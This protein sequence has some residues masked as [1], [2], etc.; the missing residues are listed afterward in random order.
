MALNSRQKHALEEFIASGVFE[1]V[2]KSIDVDTYDRFCSTNDIDEMRRIV[3]QRDNLKQFEIMVSQFVSEAYMDDVNLE[4]EKEL[5]KM[6]N[7][8]N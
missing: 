1:L 5:A 6:A 7:G 3:T 4:R 8:I 2:I